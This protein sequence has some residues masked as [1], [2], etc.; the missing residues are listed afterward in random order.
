MTPEVTTRMRRLLRLALPLGLVAMLAVPLAAQAQTTVTQGMTRLAGVPTSA[1]HRM[2]DLAFWGNRAYAGTYTGFKIYDISNPAAPVELVN[3]PCAG[4]P[5]GASQGD[6]SVWS[7]GLRTLL[8]R[9]VDTPQNRPDCTRTAQTGGAPGW[10]G[11]DIFDVSNPTAPS[12]VGG[13]ATDCGSHT[14]TLVPDVPNGRVFLYISSY[15]ASGFGA[16]AFGNQ[17][18]RPHNKIG[19]VEVPLGAPETARVARYVPM[20]L[21]E[22]AILGTTGGL[23][24]GCHDIT[25]NTALDIAAGACLSQGVMFDI[26]N[27][28]NPTV[29]H[30]LVNP[31]IDNCA[32]NVPGSPP[33][34]GQPNPNPLCLWHSATFT[35]DGK[36]AVFGDEAGGG[37]SAECSSEDPPSR[38]AFWL[39]RVSNPTNPI[40]SFKIP[41][42]QP[43]AGATWQNCTAHIM[44]FVPIN[45]RYALASSWYSGGTSVINWNN[46]N[47]PF[48]FAWFEVNP[49]VTG[50]A[51]PAQTNTWTTYWYNDHMYT[52]DGGN[53]PPGNNGGQRGFEVFTLDVGW[54][55]HAWNLPRFNPQ[56]QE[57]VIRCRGAIHG[58]RPRVGRRST[59]HVQVRVLGNQPVVG[60][61][62]LL[63]GV[64]VRMTHMTNRAG[65]VSFHGVRPRRAG[66]LRVIVPDVRNMLGCAGQVRVRRP[67]GAGVAGG[68]AGGGAGLTGRLV[69][70]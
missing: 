27:P 28:G 55:T 4:A 17:C 23:S 39:H 65:E 56:T 68:G 49:G 59:L 62:V 64:G 32:R 57:N 54:R 10:E 29:T 9:S 50:I 34:P 26:S 43:H 2:S 51:D 60:T 30:R 47:A 16:S 24:A 69:S 40:S 58:L 66:F 6:V 48:E 42:V 5:G 7:T 38:G 14:H 61:R 70:R 53:T 33:G 13:V 36:Y 22:S 46:P 67:T 41:R 12:Y 19:I 37:G 8:F 3:F 20:G 15:P 18:S 44:N 52:M 11:I 31:A 45:G 1:P 63:R 21:P 35:W 25:A